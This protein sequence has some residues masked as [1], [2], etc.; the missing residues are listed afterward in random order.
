MA[1]FFE[2]L[3]FTSDEMADTMPEKI[4]QVRNRSRCA[5]RALAGGICCVEGCCC[6]ARALLLLLCR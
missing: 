3:G 4:V 1:N 5:W 2:L 6:C